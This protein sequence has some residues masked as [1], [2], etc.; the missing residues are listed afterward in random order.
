VTTH[1]ARLG[2]AC[3]KFPFVS[4][5]KSDMPFCP[6]KEIC[7]CLG[8]NLFYVFHMEFL[9]LFSRLINFVVLWSQKFDVVHDNLPFIL[10]KIIRPVS[11]LDIY[12]AS[13]RNSLILFSHILGFR[14]KHVHEF[15][16]TVVNN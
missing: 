1:N 7:R 6:E 5:T 3:D 2:I 4:P 12:D 8:L 11:C 16:S 9:Y 13:L 10:R 15:L 14:A